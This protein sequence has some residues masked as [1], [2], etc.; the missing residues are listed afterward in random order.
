MAC[1]LTTTTMSSQAAALRGRPS[2][3]NSQRRRPWLRIQNRRH[4]P[5]AAGPGM[6]CVP[7]LPYVAL[8]WVSLTLGDSGTA[9]R[10]VR[11]G[12]RVRGGQGPASARSARL[13]CAVCGR[14][15]R[16]AQRVEREMRLAFLQMLADVAVETGG[17]SG[18]WIWKLGK[19]LADDNNYRC[20]ECIYEPGSLR[21]RFWSENE[22][23]WQC[24]WCASSP[25][26]ACRRV[27]S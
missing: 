8:T 3:W 2:T 12:C 4:L 18:N 7:T 13:S 20:A 9:V 11:G 10:R 17:G 25:G 19:Y 24:A 22:I 26:A 23:D 21:G 1:R 15:P 27:A 14:H 5:C 6:W 16:S